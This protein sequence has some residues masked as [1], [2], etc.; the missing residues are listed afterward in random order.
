MGAVD[1][2][3]LGAARLCH[4]SAQE[5]FRLRLKLAVCQPIRRFQ[6]G[7]M[8]EGLDAGF[9]NES[10]H[11]YALRREFRCALTDSPANTIPEGGT[12]VQVPTKAAPTRHLLD[13]DLVE[14]GIDT[15]SFDSRPH[16]R[17]G[18]LV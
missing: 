14:R 12:Y 8:R 9:Q 11:P 18:H 2:L 1:R 16:K 5:Q 15:V 6:N 13:Q 3:L 7:P 4:I 10:Y 17:T